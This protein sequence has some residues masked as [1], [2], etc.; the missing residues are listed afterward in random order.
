MVILI[1]NALVETLA[2][3]MFSNYLDEQSQIKI[4]G[5]PSWYMQPVDNQICTFSHKKG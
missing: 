5:A 2:K 1:A 4:G 3:Y